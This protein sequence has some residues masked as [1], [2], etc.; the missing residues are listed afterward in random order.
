MKNQNNDPIAWGTR[1]EGRQLV[2]EC[3]FGNH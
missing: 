2:V 3:P 1:I